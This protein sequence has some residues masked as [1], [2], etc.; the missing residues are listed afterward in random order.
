MVDYSSPCPDSS[1]EAIINRLGMWGTNLHEIYW[2]LD[3]WWKIGGSQVAFGPTR[4]AP[5]TPRFSCSIQYKYIKVIPHMSWVVINPSRGSGTLCPV[6]SFQALYHWITLESVV[7]QCRSHK[8]DVQ[9][10]DT[11][12]PRTPFYSRRVTPLRWKP[13]QKFSTPFR[14]IPIL[15]LLKTT[16]LL[17]KPRFVG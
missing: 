10:I 13:F 1:S 11:F 4:R 5:C 6:E 3:W 2:N 7:H 9:Y 16:C 17:L 15:W 8:K 12:W 14:P